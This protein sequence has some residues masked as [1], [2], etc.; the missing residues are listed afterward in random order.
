MKTDERLRWFGEVGTG[1]WTWKMKRE[2]RQWEAS[3]EAADWLELKGLTFN[4][5]LM[6]LIIV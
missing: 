2:R 5:G 4:S 6:S 1:R 3:V